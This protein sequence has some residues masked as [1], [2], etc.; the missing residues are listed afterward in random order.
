MPRLAKAE[1]PVELYYFYNNECSAC[2][3]MSQ[4]LE[5]LRDKYSGVMI[6]R[7][8]VTDDLNKLTIFSDLLNIYREPETSVPTVFIGNDVFVGYTAL[9]TNEIDK[10]I[11]FCQS[12][13]CPSPSSLLKD[14]YA[15]LSVEEEDNTNT[16]IF[17][18]IFLV[19]WPLLG[20]VAV[21][22]VLKKYK[23]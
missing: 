13:D 7:F 5:S 21:I 4:A 15:S 10:A 1:T 16:I 22:L 2:T 6:N 11:L 18:T 23:R 19:T 20:A 17:W 8:D 12:N 3:D 14:Y 9:S